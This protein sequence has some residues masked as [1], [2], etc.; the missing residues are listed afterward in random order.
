MRKITWNR[1]L[2]KFAVIA[3]AVLI[4]G[5]VYFIRGGEKEIEPGACTDGADGSIEIVDCDHSDAKYKV[6]SFAGTDGLPNQD[7]P[8]CEVGEAYT[9][10]TEDTDRSF[11]P[12]WC[13][14]DA[15]DDSAEVEQAIEEAKRER[16]ENN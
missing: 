6:V 13:L 14:V 15:D 1:E 7:P 10:V 2:I 5:A 4:G 3:L 8:E 16:E 11:P 9:L 12:V